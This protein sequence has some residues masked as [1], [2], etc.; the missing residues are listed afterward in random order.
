LNVRAPC[1]LSFYCSLSALHQGKQ[2][3]LNL[4][5]YASAFDLD[6]RFGNMD[7]LEDYAQAQA[8]TPSMPAIRKDLGYGHH[9]KPRFIVLRKALA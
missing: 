6:T 9:E 2:R 3:H 1:L 4:E 5:V 8:L 7:R